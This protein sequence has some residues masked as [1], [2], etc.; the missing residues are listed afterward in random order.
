[1]LLSCCTGSFTIVKS[2]KVAFELVFKTIISYV[3]KALLLL[4]GHPSRNIVVIENLIVRHIHKERREVVEYRPKTCFSAMEFTVVQSQSSNLILDILDLEHGCSPLLFNSIR[5]FIK[6]Q[7]Y[8]LKE[9]H[10]LDEILI[11]LDCWPST[12][13][14]IQRKLVMRLDGGL[15][16]SP[17]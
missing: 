9:G 6:S 4:H 5:K 7:N 3:L 10:S 11:N 12:V 2:C 17:N 8:Q 1:L 16:E 13:R 14:Q 15:T